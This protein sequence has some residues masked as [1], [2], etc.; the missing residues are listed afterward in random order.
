MRPICALELWTNVIFVG[1]PTGSSTSHYGDSRKFTLLNSALT[2]RVSSV[3]WRDYE[4]NEK[5]P[6]IAPDL[7]AP[8]S[9]ADYFGGRDPAMRAI[10]SFVPPGSLYE[11][12]KAAYLANGLGSA[13]LQGYKFMSDP[14]NASVDLEGD[15]NRL[16]EYLISRKQY[17][18]AGSVYQWNV[19]DH[20][21][22]FDAHIGLG[23][24]Q[25]LNGNKAEALKA[26]LNALKIKPGDA[27]AQ[28]LLKRAQ[29]K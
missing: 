24:A 3:Y 6:L 21:S 1:E 11:R 7:P 9:A 12:L 27:K 23:E 5:R 18:D 4:S 15:L 26:L 2:L 16:G 20:P 29:K 14:D 13:Y 25:L 22:S 10:Q 8:P 17:A 19:D 28:A